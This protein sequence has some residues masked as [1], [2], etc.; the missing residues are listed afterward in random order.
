MVPLEPKVF[1]VRSRYS[2]GTQ[3]RQGIT[4]GYGR[5]RYSGCNRST[6]S[7]RNRWCLC[8]TRYSRY[9]KVF[10]VLQGITGTTGGQ[11]TQGRQSVVQGVLKADKELLVPTGGQGT[12][13]RQGRQGTQG[14][15]GTTGD[16]RYSRYTSVLQGV[17]KEQTGTYR[18]SR[19][20]R[21]VKVDRVLKADKVL[22]V[23]L[24][25]KVLKDAN[26]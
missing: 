23:I 20:S 6:R 15:Q 21:Y 19:Y 18:R 8:R 17:Y 22:K 16:T 9:Y 12:Q 4:R 7:S 1:K 24:A 14:T 13:G 3:G 11:G 25:T 10:K 26:R 5:A 2:A